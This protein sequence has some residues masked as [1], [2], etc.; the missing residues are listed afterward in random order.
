[1]LG[2]KR[3]QGKR[4]DELK[5]GESVHEKKV[6]AVRDIVL[7][8]GLTDDTNPVFVEA[9]YVHQ[10]PYEQLL[11]PSGLL[12]GWVE[13]LISTKLPGAGSLICAQSLTFPKQ[14]THGERVECSLEVIHKD[15][16]QQRIS[17]AV[18]IQNEQS[19][20]VTVGEIQVIPPI[21]K[22]ILQQTYDNF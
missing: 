12:S 4:W 18:H 13:S 1:M 2:Q 5:I 21:T 3:G 19:E 10:T 8:L 6:L 20:D 22:S 9:N 7:Y 14:V 17:V 11:V 15:E 16:I